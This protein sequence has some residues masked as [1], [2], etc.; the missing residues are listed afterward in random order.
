[1]QVQGEVVAKTVVSKALHTSMPIATAA[2]H[3]MPLTATTTIPLSSLAART[4]QAPIASVK[5]EYRGLVGTLTTISRQE[6]PRA[7]YNGLSAGLQRQMCFASVRLGLYDSV[8]NM[9]QDV[10]H[11][12]PQGMQIVTRIMAGLTT[13]GLAVVLAQPTDV[14]KVRFQAQRKGQSTA[15]KP[16]YKS[17]L[18][19]Y[20]TIGRTEGMAGLWKGAIPNIGRNAVVNVSEIV[21]YDIVKDCLLQYSRLNDNIYCHFTAAVIAGK[22]SLDEELTFFMRLAGEHTY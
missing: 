1:M 20:R 17:T 9:Y 15:S 18:Q 14:V 8:K 5:P 16:R 13:G 4:V 10:L 19:A 12:N 2:L 6:G 22:W 21:C 7:L 11:E 3:G